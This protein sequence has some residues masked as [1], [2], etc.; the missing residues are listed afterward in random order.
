[1]NVE[2]TAKYGMAAA[3]IAMESK[4]PVNPKIYVEEVMRRMKD[5]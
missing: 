3:S 2:E 1:M 5:E 4:T